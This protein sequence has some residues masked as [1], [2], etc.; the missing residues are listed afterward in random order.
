M[1]KTT[2]VDKKKKKAKEGRKK[3]GSG[4]FDTLRRAKAKKDYEEAKS[5]STEALLTVPAAFPP[6]VVGAE[7]N[8]EDAPS[9]VPTIKVVPKLDFLQAEPSGTSVVAVPCASY[10]QVL[11]VSTASEFVCTCFVVGDLLTQCNRYRGAAGAAN[12]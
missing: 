11:V 9:L 7:A 2:L 4:L 6:P 8:G 3:R 10:T 12:E 5:S 1:A